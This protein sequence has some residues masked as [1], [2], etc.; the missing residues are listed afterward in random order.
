MRRLDKAPEPEDFLK[1]V[2]QLEQS[3]FDKNWVSWFLTDLRKTN[4][5]DILLKETSSNCSYCE[6]YL[7]KSN[8][9][10]DTFY[11]KSKFPE[12]RFEWKNL[13]LCCQACNTFKGNKFPIDINGN[14]L[15][16]N[17]FME[18]VDIHFFYNEQGIIFPIS[19]KGNITI[20]V[21]GLNRRELIDYRK[22]EYYNYLYEFKEKINLLN[23]KP[24]IQ[25]T[26]CL[27]YLL[28]KNYPL[29][30]NEIILE[31]KPSKKFVQ[32][33]YDLSNLSAKD[34][35]IYKT[36]T[37]YLN[38]LTIYKFKRIDFLKIKL[39][40]VSNTSNY[41]PCLVF[42][43][44]NGTGKTTILQAIS[45]GLFSKSDENLIINIVKKQNIKLKKALIKIN[46]SNPDILSRLFVGKNELKIKNTGQKV[47]FLG[48]GTVGL[49]KEN[50]VNLKIH[51]INN[52]FN[53]NDRLID[54]KKWLMGLDDNSF[55]VVTEIIC[56]LLKSNKMF[57]RNKT[58]IL[59]DDIVISD[60]SEGE[61]YLISLVVNILANMS[62]IWNNSI[63]KEDILDYSAVVIVDEIGAHLH[64][65]WKMKIISQ[66]RKTFPKLQ[67]ICTT[68]DPLCLKGF[69]QGE[70]VVLR[71]DK[72]GN[73]FMIN[74]ED[75]PNPEAMRADQLLTSPYFGLS[76]TIDP[77]IEE[78]FEEYYD[79]LAREEELNSD[80]QKRYEYL[81]VEL[82]RSER[83]GDTE[84]EQLYYEVIDKVLAERKSQD[85]LK[86]ISTREDILQR[87]NKIL[88]EK[89]K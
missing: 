43:G 15:L 32:M 72:D 47:P 77:E 69:K 9:S 79:L 3:N 50:Y 63:I 73:V 80:E 61:K 4:I 59:F 37:I 6:K 12:K 14:P 64:P 71:K 70:I 2:K 88:G 1:I 35:A 85:H 62:L 24:Q 78:A 60:L 65:T 68:H 89:E 84:R 27:R 86:E 20:E 40:Q 57:I 33:N 52:L 21:L 81:K 8:Y 25:F 44:E 23:K 42:L 19:E 75:L 53:A 13:I 51:N 82:G 45:L 5:P 11:P 38:A 22:K 76:S 39:N 46:Y 41:I 34:I 55:Q 66:L 87:I 30:T 7:D 48:Y 67:F 28:N 18:N 29:F 83:F 10:L 74:Q 17:P 49:V 16:L 58:E 56:S 36:N 31:Y 54:F 26:G